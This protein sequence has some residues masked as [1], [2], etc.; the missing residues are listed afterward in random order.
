MTIAPYA[1]LKKCHE[2]SDD[3]TEKKGHVSVRE[4]AGR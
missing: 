4:Q 2:D 1:L 3:R